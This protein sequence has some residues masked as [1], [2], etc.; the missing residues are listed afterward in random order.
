M[1]CEMAQDERENLI[2][3]TIIWAV[4]RRLAWEIQ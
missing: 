1:D 3:I 4:K 2:V